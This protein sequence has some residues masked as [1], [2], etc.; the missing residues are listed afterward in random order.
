MVFPPSIKQ[1][2]PGGHAKFW[3][4]SI[5]IAREAPVVGV[6][7]SG[8]N[9]DILRTVKWSLSLKPVTMFLPGPTGSLH[10]RKLHRTMTCVVRTSRSSVKIVDPVET[11]EGVNALLVQMLYVCSY[12]LY[13]PV[14]LYPIDGISVYGERCRYC[15]S[16]G[17]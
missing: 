7:R 15:Q 1:S 10:R 8:V 16:C 17:E 6:V 12:Q 13:R 9:Y 5:L 2:P 11:A 14:C 4:N 3:C